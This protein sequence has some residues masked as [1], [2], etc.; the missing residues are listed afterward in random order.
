VSDRA[1][2]L[3][4]I[5]P[6]TQFE[7]QAHALGIKSRRLG[8]AGEAGRSDKRFHEG[9]FG[10]FASGWRMHYWERLAKYLG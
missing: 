5:L 6:A 8:D 10:D 3:R 1:D 7:G 2:S 4:L 9:D